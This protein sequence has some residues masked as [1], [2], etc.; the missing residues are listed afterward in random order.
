MQTLSI[1]DVTITSIVERDGPWRKPEDMFP[2]YDRV[3]G[4]QHLKELDPEVFDPESGRM[5]ITYQ[6]FI[7]RTPKHTVLIDTCT[8]EDKGY[9]PPMDF[10]KQPWLDNFRAAGLSFED[11]D[12]VFCT[13]LHIDHT[14]WN[15][16]LRDGRWV[17]SFPR[18]KYIFHKGEY[19]YW[20]AATERGANPP[21][22]VW[23]YNCRP[24]VESGQA[25]LVDD[26]YQLDDTFAL[27]P[28]PGHSP[29]HCC[30]DIRSRGQHAV[31]TGDLMHHALQC[32]EPDWSTIFDTD[33]EQAA[34]S[35]RRFL[36]GVADTSTRVLPIHFP[37]PT[38]GLVA[39]D[40]G[41]FR[42]KFLR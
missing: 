2:A 11:I 20:E 3:V 29:H 42:Y 6:T 25:L 36:S 31:V 41:R 18:A 24:V 40:G 5:V 33:K 27:T 23:S 35:R 9:P 12:Y 14:G 22:N 34:R 15:T 13:H 37:H 17:P 1:G 28:T 32:R 4:R 7:V 8:G 30:I 10:P 39:A 26:S 19:A 21:G 16:Q 38:V